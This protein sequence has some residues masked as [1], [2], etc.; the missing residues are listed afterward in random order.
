MIHA[1]RVM[2]VLRFSHAYARIRRTS[3]RSDS[4]AGP[5]RPREVHFA[6][7]IV[8]LFPVAGCVAHPE[9]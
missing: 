9:P 1:E 5:N 3:A 4:M 7:S 6:P 2:L 8:A